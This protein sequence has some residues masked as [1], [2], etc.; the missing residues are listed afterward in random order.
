[1]KK[2]YSV[3]MEKEAWGELI[4]HCFEHKKNEVNVDGFRKGQVPFDVY[5]KKFGVESLYMDAVDHA[6]PELYDKLLEENEG[7]SQ[8]GGSGRPHRQQNQSDGQGQ[9]NPRGHRFRLRQSGRSG[10]R[11]RF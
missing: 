1:M 11:Q 7:L 9:G 2:D 5:V 3:K 4:H 10:P 6:L 8:R